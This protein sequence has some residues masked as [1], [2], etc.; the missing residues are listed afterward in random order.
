MD[1][2][3]KQRIQLSSMNIP[4]FC[5]LCSSFNEPLFAICSFVPVFFPFRINHFSRFKH[6]SLFPLKTFPT[7]EN[8][9]SDSKQKRTIRYNGKS[10]EWLLHPF[11]TSNVPYLF[12]RSTFYCLR[13]ILLSQHNQR[14]FNCTVPV[15]YLLCCTIVQQLTLYNYTQLYAIIHEVQFTLRCT[16]PL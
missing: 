4:F 15:L 5:T 10:N 16:P 6:Y 1:C 7:V 12:Q 2:K 14:T 3:N 13:T 9:Y 11:R 8:H